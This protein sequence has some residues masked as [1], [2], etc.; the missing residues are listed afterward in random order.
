M[1]STTCL[2]TFWAVGKVYVN[3]SCDLSRNG[4]ARQVARN[5]AQCHSVLRGLCVGLK[6]RALLG[7]ALDSQSLSL[8]SGV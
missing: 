3:V 4:V 6:G 8:H 1:V 5:I 2:A 7:K